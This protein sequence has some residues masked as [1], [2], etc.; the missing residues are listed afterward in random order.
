MSA[1][2]DA[3]PAIPE[4]WDSLAP[5]LTKAT[6]FCTPDL[7]ESMSL[8][9]G[10]NQPFS[11]LQQA[12]VLVVGAGGLGCEILKNLALSGFTD[13]HVI[14]MDTIDLSNLNRQFLFREGDV[15]KGKAATAAA[16]VM[17]RVKGVTVTHYE[18]KIQDF[19]KI[20]YSQFSVVISGLDNIAA[21]EWL[22]ET[23]VDLVTFD[24]DGNPN[25][26]Q[27]PF[28]DGGVE[29]FAGQCRVFWPRTA[30]CF[31]CALPT[32][33]PPVGFQE[34]TVATVPRLPEH[35]ITFAKNFMWPALTS[36]TD[37]DTFVL[38]EKYVKD[39]VKGFERN[40]NPLELDKDDTQHMTWLFRQATI[41][42]QKYNIPGVTYQKTMQVVKNIIPAIAA[43]N[44][45]LSAACALEAFKVVTSASKNLNNWFKFFGAE[46]AGAQSDTFLFKQNPD[47]KV[48]RPILTLKVPA[49][50]TLGQLLV[51]IKN[52][53]PQGIP[54]FVKLSEN[55]SGKRVWFK[56]YD[57]YSVVG[58]LAA[59][60]TEA[61]ASATVLCAEIDAKVGSFKVLVIF[62]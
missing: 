4:K 16:F 33:T 11:Q 59:P 42:A 50:T 37:A 47:C 41:R 3:Y 48:C 34:C 57:E 51:D 36:F 27:I 1:M 62:T 44:A 19:G 20:W 10:A 23:L 39:D 32:L 56:G 49:A 8:S 21:R 26:G 22:N 7:F 24:E 60:V 13:L 45:T 2:E 35:C 46:K 25:G 53:L 29:G 61:F 31:Q 58:N 14:D 6:P 5:I 18:K 15:K 28:I 30:A 40:P 17:K 9:K 55:I 12:P 54:A 52:V 38:N 43:T